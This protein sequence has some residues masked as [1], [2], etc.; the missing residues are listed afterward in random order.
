[1]AMDKFR[2]HHTM[3]TINNPE[4][5]PV[6]QIEWLGDKAQYRDEKH[7]V[8]E[9]DARREV[10]KRARTILTQIHTGEAFG[11]TMVVSTLG[12]KENR[13]A[14]KWLRVKDSSRLNIKNDIRWVKMPSDDMPTKKE[15]IVNTH[16]Q[17][18]RVGRTLNE[19]LMADMY[20]PMEATA[21]LKL[22]DN[23]TTHIA[24]LKGA[25]RQTELMKMW[26][27]NNQWTRA[28]RENRNNGFVHAPVCEK[29]RIMAS[30][31]NS[32][33]MEMTVNTEFMKNSHLVM[34][35]ELPTLG[36]IVKDPVTKM[37]KRNKAS[38]MDLITKFLTNKFVKFP[39]TIKPSYLEDKKKRKM[40]VNFNPF[41]KTW[42]MFVDN[43]KMSMKVRDIRP[44]EMLWKTN[45]VYNVNNDFGLSLPW[46][47]FLN[48]NEGFSAYE[49]NLDKA[50]REQM[51]EA[52]SKCV[53]DERFIK[54]FDNV[55]FPVD[56]A[57]NCWH[58]IAGDCSQKT[59]LAVLVKQMGSR[60]AV[61]VITSTRII[62]LLPTGLDYYLKVDKKD[63]R[64]LPVGQLLVLESANKETE[65]RLLKWTTD[66]LE[67][68]LP[69][70]GAR[71]RIIGAAVE[72]QLEPKFL[73]NRACGICGDMNGETYQDLTGPKRC[74]MFTGR[75]LQT[76]YMADK[77]CQ[78][79]V[80]QGYGD[81]CVK[82]KREQWMVQPPPTGGY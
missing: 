43:A 33:N 61:R 20:A 42:D 9:K 15:L 35:N 57:H 68:E 51:G 75:D 58:M 62:E 70:Y 3:E 12:M 16:I 18:P 56:M 31:L 14:L 54:T 73:R 69:V 44:T 28:C 29:A 71:L 34:E 24:T 22:N 55:T 37:V 23:R 25:L 53:I 45:G 66:W 77:Q 74:L 76:I 50:R 40:S 81:D 26:S 64:L 79:Q 78:K 72:L 2:R 27:A 63:Q 47:P 11:W 32:I 21:S 46:M 60:R 6:E 5:E 48:I 52:R 65:A 39:R 38:F 67:L 59:N 19:L 8:V 7:A 80:P 49:D 36:W 17:W 41:S 82:V 30:R 1:L 10:M 4:A 13:M